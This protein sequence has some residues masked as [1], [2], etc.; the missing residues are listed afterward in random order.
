MAADLV[1]ANATPPLNQ[2]Y[3]RTVSKINA[4]TCRAEAKQ[5]YAMKDHKHLNM[6]LECSEKWASRGCLLILMSR[7][8]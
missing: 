5:A 8:E 1:A 4:E 2:K 6:H 3:G 7:R